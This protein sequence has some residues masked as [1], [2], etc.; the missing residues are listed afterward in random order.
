MLPPKEHLQTFLNKA[1][2]IYMRKPVKYKGTLLDFDDHLNLKLESTY[3]NE[4]FV[5]NIVLNGGS[6]AAIECAKD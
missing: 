6:I 4:E 3:E 2:T 1:V 5:G